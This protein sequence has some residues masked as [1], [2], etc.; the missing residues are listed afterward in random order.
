MTDGSSPIE[1]SS[2]ILPSIFR[3]LEKLGH[4]RASIF[5]SAGIRYAAP[6]DESCVPAKDLS[7]LFNYA[8]CL[9]ASGTD[10]QARKGFVK[11]IVTDMLLYCVITCK[12]LEEVI[13]RTAVY[14]GLVESIGISLRLIQKERRAEL[15]ID[16]GRHTLDTPSLLLTVAAMSTFYHLFS[17]IT[18]TNLK[19][20]EV[21]LRYEAPDFSVSLGALQQQ[22]LFY[23]RSSDYFIFPAAYLALPVARTYD[24]LT[25]VI[26]YFPVSLISTAAED[27]TLASRIR[28][29]VLSSLSS[30]SPPMTIEVAA[31]LANLSS[32]TLRRKLRNEG[33]SFSEILVICQQ[34]EAEKYLRGSTPIKT[35][36]L[37]LGF[38]DDRAFRRAFNRWSGQTPTEFRKRC[39]RSRNR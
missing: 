24:Q 7:T 25:Q 33:T 8:C 16:I 23:N 10:N 14:C 6:G 17:W 31:Q 22:P 29:I 2:I 21:G 34:V 11:K 28:G 38:S 30:F 1:T 4:D 32:A 35:I 15:R 37:Q 19:L 39:Q 5:S 36:A 9:L 18:A 3:E 20:D 27:T 26:D 13:E 12:D